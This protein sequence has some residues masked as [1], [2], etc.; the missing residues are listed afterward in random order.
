MTYIGI[1]FEVAASND[2]RGESFKRNM[3]DGH[4][5]GRTDGHW[6]L[7]GMELKYPFFSK[8]KSGYSNNP[9][10]LWDVQKMSENA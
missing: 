10:N 3:T 4:T 2:L 1:K 6:T 8:E 7:F 9:L 5:D